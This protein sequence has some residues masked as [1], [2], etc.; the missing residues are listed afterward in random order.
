[1]RFLLS[2]VPSDTKGS[3]SPPCRP[4]A[5]T[6]K[7]AYNSHRKPFKHQQE[8]AVMRRGIN[9]RKSRRIF[10]KYSRSRR[11]NHRPPVRRG[12]IRF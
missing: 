5:M 6:K 9:R 12:G 4:F 3:H 1:M 11:V 8:K 10:R 7:R 2:T